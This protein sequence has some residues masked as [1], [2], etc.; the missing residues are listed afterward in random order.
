MKTEIKKLNRFTTLPI[1]L[2]LLERQKLVL[3]DPSSWDDKNDTLIIEEYKKK[4]TIDKL[5]V[6]CFTHESETIHHWKAFASGSSGCC[7]EFDAVKLRKIFDNTSQVRHGIVEYKK[8]N[9][10]KQFF[11]DLQ[12]IPFIKRKPYEFE[13]EYRVI[14]EGRSDNKYY[15]LEVPLEI[16]KRITFGQ[17]MPESVFESVKSM[18]VKNYSILNKKIF[19]STVYKNKTWIKNFRDK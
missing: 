6:L 13:R 19:R 11:L 12:N 16:I 2:D 15:E 10:S 5:F 14:W 4:A 18:L 7:V 9:D 17:Q 1:L 3:L 8:I